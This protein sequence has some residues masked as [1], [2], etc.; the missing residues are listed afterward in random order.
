MLEA[1]IAELL[2][3][4]SKSLNSFLISL[5]WTK[6]QGCLAMR[7]TKIH[8]HMRVQKG[9]SECTRKLKQD[10]TG[11]LPFGIFADQKNGVFSVINL[12][13]RRLQLI[14]MEYGYTSS[15]PTASILLC[16]STTTAC[17]LRIKKTTHSLTHMLYTG[18]KEQS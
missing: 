18:R 1:R 11:V 2:A 13:V 4:P 8:L 14:T 10:R 5:I 17:R 9:T 15:I 12:P 3:M 6:S 16:P 7:K